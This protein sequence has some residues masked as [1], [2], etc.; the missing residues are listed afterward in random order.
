MYKKKIWRV[1]VKRAVEDWVEVRADPPLQAE[2]LAINVP[3]VIS[4]FGRSAI[5]GDTPVH[6]PL[7]VGVE[8]PD[9]DF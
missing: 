1:R 4:V 6:R 3:G 5:R 7:P 8:D 9:E 2:E